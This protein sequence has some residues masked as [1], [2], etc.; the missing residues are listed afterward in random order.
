MAIEVR[1]A[2]AF[3]WSIDWKDTK[4]SLLEGQRGHYTDAYLCKNMVKLSLYSIYIIF[5]FKKKIKRNRSWGNCHLRFASI[6]LSL[7]HGN[8]GSPGGRFS[9]WGSQ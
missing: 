2:F 6:S 3:G 5:P 7:D 4:G 1:T 9:L 8:L